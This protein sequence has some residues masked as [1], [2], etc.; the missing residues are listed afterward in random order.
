VTELSLTA[1]ARPRSRVRAHARRPALAA[2]VWV[3]LAGNS[4]VITWLWL[5]GGGVSAT[6]TVGDAF[7]SVGRLTGMLAAY[8]ALLQVVLLARIPWIERVTG[9]DRLSV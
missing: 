7:T 4:G 6:H 5:H 3:V 1:I 8:S 2:L 9:F